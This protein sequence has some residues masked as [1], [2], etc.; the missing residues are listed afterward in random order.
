MTDAD[1]IIERLVKML[2]PLE[3]LRIVEMAE[4]A[5]LS[6]LSTDQLTRDYP[7]K[8]VKLSKRR[9]GMRVAHALML[10]EVN[11]IAG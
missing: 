1:Q 2:P 8:V 7:D 11:D 6:S 9:N 5:R 3:L 4:A 10:R